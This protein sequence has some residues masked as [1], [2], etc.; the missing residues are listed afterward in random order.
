MDM[1]KDLSRR[2]TSE[3]SSNIVRDNT[4]NLNFECHLRSESVPGKVS[5]QSK[6]RGSCVMDLQQNF[7]ENDI[8]TVSTL[9]MSLSPPPRT[10]TSQGNQKEMTPSTTCNTVSDTA[11]ASMSS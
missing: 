7:E 5:N 1:M 10:V 6:K 8:N 11:S 3:H 4:S 2:Q 9:S